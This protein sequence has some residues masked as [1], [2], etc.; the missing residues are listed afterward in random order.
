M[1]ITM[2]MFLVALCGETLATE[3]QRAALPE[4]RC[5]GIETE[6]VRETVVLCYRNHL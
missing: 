6:D 1:P 5:L 3:N 2:E 4:G